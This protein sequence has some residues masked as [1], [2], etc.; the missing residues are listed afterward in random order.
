MLG[1]PYT[2]TSLFACGKVLHFIEFFTCCLLIRE[3][4]L[5]RQN[6]RSVSAKCNKLLLVGNTFHT[7][8]A[9]KFQNATSLGLVMHLAG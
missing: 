4:C 3:F 8:F 2:V 5:V 1:I 6:K 7:I 9:D